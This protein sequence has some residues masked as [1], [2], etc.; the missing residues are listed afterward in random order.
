MPDDIRPDPHAILDRA[1]LRSIYKQP[2]DGAVRKVL[3]R[4][5]VHCRAYIEK[6]QFL[7]LATSD[8]QGKLD[9][10]PKG[11]PAGF[12]KAR[13]DKTIMLPDWPGNNRLDGLENII[14]NPHVGVLLFVPGMNEMLR[15]NG[16]AHIT[17]DPALKPMFKTDGKLPISIIVIEIDQVYLHCARALQRSALWDVSRHIDRAKDFPTMGK[18]LAD[19][20]AGYDGVATDQMIEKHKNELY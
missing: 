14:T 5:D 9:A 17:T 2:G 4:L 7:V 3:T 1:G 11:G 18:M 15:L 10:S 13:D 12:A 8:A 20:I 6:C 19:Q 16:R